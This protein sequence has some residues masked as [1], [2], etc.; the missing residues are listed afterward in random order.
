MKTLELTQEELIIIQDLIST[1]RFRLLNK[2]EEDVNILM[3]LGIVCK[4]NAR[5]KRLIEE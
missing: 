1:E 4:L 3:V 5:C 2:E